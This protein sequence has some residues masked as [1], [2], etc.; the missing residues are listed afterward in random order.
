MPFAGFAKLVSALLDLLGLLARSE[1]ENTLETLLL[2]Q[3][4]R[5]LPRTQVRTPRL[6]WWENLPLTMLAG[7]LIQGAADSRARLSH[8]L[9]L[10]SPQTVLQLASRSGA[11]QVDL[12]T[13]ARFRQAPH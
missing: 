9:L 4:L 5:S 11:P 2:R 3:Q 10:F 1:P 12:P 7:N 8:S 13:S 6:S